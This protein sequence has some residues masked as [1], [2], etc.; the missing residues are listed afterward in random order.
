MTRPSCV[1]T[2]VTA[3]S[4]RISA[5]KDSAARASTWVNPP[6][7]PLWNAQVPT[8]PSCSPMLWNS[9]T[10]PDP[11]DIGPTLVP[12]IPEEHS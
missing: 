7:P 6:L 1:V 10:R 8:R 2:A 4:R 9:S 11:W 12:M 3:E 5:P